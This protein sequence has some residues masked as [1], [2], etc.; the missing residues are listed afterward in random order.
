MGG[1]RVLMWFLLV[2]SQR[3]WLC[4]PPVVLCGLDGALTLWGQPPQYWT[5]GYN[6]FHEANPLAAWLL[7]V[8]PLA[9]AAAG[10]AYCLGVCA[11][12]S[13]LPLRYSVA[14]T[15]LVSLGHAVGVVSWVA[16]LIRR[17]RGEN[18]LAGAPGFDVSHPLARR[19]RSSPLD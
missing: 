11:A 18:D 4:V 10:L 7:T 19:L 14:M 17:Q 3:L 6:T 16:T 2:I 13:W 5:S 15:T 9:F 12:V 1:C 8:H